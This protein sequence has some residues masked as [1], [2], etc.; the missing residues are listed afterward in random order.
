MVV[1]S[2]LVSENSLGDHW[3]SSMKAI[4]GKEGIRIVKEHEVSLEVQSSPSPFGIY[5]MNNYD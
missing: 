1:K 2:I 5:V 4:E 3:T